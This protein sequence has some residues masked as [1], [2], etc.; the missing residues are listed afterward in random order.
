M[1]IHPAAPHHKVH[2]LGVRDLKNFPPAQ[3][4]FKFT[5]Y[6]YPAAGRSGIT[7]GSTNRDANAVGRQRR[8]FSA[9]GSTRDGHAFVNFHLRASAA[10][11]GGFSWSF[12]TAARHPTAPEPV[13][14]FY[15]RQRRCIDGGS[16]VLSRH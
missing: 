12:S 9:A 16:V 13:V 5:R 3:L 4:A 6:G 8:K 10:P 11:S 15:G 2:Y 14:A 7:A 1:L